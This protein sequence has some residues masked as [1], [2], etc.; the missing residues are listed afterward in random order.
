MT[1]LDNMRYDIP[2]LMRVYKGMA[3]L[4]APP[5]KSVLTIG[6]FDGVHLGHQDLLR[7]VH[8]H[9]FRIGGLPMALTF[10]P[11]PYF[12]LRPSDAPQLINTYEEKIELLGTYGIQCVMEE[13]FSREF[14]NIT[15][16]EFVKKHLIENLG[17]QVL[18]LGYDFAF[19]KARSGSVDT[20]KRLAEE[21]GIEIHVVPARK[22]GEKT[23]SSSLIRKS[24][25]AG[26][27]AFVNQCLGRKFFLRGLV[28]RGEGRGRT[29]G[30]P[31]ANM[32]TVQRKYP[33]VGVYA[34]RT[35]WRGKHYPSVSNVGYNPTFKG[36]A[37]DL[38]LKIETHLFDFEADMYGDEIQVDFLSFLR[39]E[40]KFAGVQELLAQMQLDFA[41]A[42]AKNLEEKL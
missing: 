19:G 18:Y 2:R 24:L 5:G 10:R 16:E 13:P 35:L 7:N 23:V 30:V 11:H 4:S 28:W 38:P 1:F 41:A 26:D 34:T 33:R 12:V 39:T 20:L 3:D 32:Q 17:T 22:I 8:E 21:N 15:P 27:I 25:E 9:A 6:N 31:T 42:R 29:I 37:D 40:K 14:S 36:D